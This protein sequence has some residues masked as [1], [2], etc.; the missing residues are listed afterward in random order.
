MKKILPFLFLFT[1]TLIAFSYQTQAS[2]SNYLPGGK[3][4]IDY[5]NF[6]FQEGANVF[7]TGQPILVKPETDYV[8]WFSE[9]L[10]SPLF[11]MYFSFYNNDNEVNSGMITEQEMDYLD[12]GDGGAHYFTFRTGESINYF[13]FEIFESEVT[14]SSKLI[15]MEI[16]LEEGTS[17]STYEEYIAGSMIDTSSPYFQ[18][19][20]TIISYV[21]QPIT[22]AEI[23]S[24]LIAYDKIDGDVSSNI[25]VIS[26]GYSDFMNQIGSYEIVFSVTDLS[27]NETLTTVTVE[28]VDVLAP[29][30][31]EL[32]SIEAVYPNVYTLEDI[33]G[34]LTANDNYDGDIS[35][36]IVMVTD[37]YTANASLVGEY[38]MSFKVADSS[39]NESLHYL[40]VSVV[41]D[42]A[43]LI[44]GQESIH[45]GYN[46][47]YSE[48]DI[49]SSMSVID[50]YDDSLELIIE[51][52]NYKNNSEM[53][54][55]YNVVL[56]VT[57]SS[58]NTSQK[59]LV[60][61]VIDQVGPLVYL[62]KSVIQVYSDTVL[63]LPDF[64]HL[65]TKT[66]E[67]DGTKNYIYSTRYDNYT[68][69]SKKAG[70]YSIGLT[71]EDEQ[72]NIL[73]KDFQVKVIDRGIDGIY[74]G[75]DNVEESFIKKYED[76]FIYGGI[77]TA[78]IGSQILWFVIT[79]KKKM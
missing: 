3:N 75:Q 29:I 58:G 71:F 20:G 46:M 56:S 38:E 76:Y 36:Q 77:G 45:I 72:G 60:I 43:P 42:E 65:L 49:L 7:S 34:M 18:T 32:S 62:D 13:W 19:S 1:I 8:F 52:N 15:G 37:N 73:N 9:R 44:T 27:E 30:F 57:D 24:S 41:D 11:E 67:L 6:S 78:F 22:V 63:Q 17:P 31:G 23:Q 68:K 16:Q 26:D 69:H 4:Y 48:S 59:T 5:E 74:F 64:L 51:S 35:S 70:I 21:D 66:K 39:G 2:Q 14:D 53:I 54:G 28:V 25:T 50:N 10:M 40:T 55:Q 33:K 47:V 79:R 12:L 61:H